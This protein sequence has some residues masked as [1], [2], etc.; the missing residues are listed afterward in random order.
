MYFD[1]EDLHPDTPHIEPTVSKRDGVALSLVVHAL[2]FALI[3]FMPPLG[4]EAQ[5]E[6]VRQAE[7]AELA[8]QEALAIERQRQRDEQR[9]VFVQPRVELEAPRAPER[10]ELSDL[11]REARAPERAA[12][13][14][15][16]LPFSRGNSSERVIA[17]EPPV[18]ELSPERG[19]DEVVAE[20]TSREAEPRGVADAE[21]AEAPPDDVVP[22][23]ERQLAAVLPDT[24]SPL[25]LV[26]PTAGTGIPR[27]GSALGSALRDLQRYVDRENFSNPQGG[28][29]QFG[30][31]IDF[32]T[33]GVEFGPW[34]R[35]FVAQ[36]KRNW[37]VPRASWAFRGRVVMTFNVHKN[38]AITDLTVLQPSA[39][40][41]FNVS[42]FNALMGSNPTYPL[43]PEYPSDRAF[44][45]VTFFYNESPD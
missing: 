1:F 40:E 38:G 4:R 35:R 36:V 34:I 16:P 28:G 12:E 3:L 39:I 45:T 21:G 9:F 8:R 31:W 11:D 6:A 37:I 26:P 2:L 33:K 5:L 13:P 10:A 14:T 17:D 43:P 25:G 20:D 44:F 23:P 42:S 27:P 19:T 32:D 29:G 30:S 7:E 41:G 22:E 24:R 18:E 15:N